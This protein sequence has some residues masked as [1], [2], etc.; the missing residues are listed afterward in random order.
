MKK[1]ISIIYSFRDRDLDRVKVSLDS[2]KRQTFN[3]FEVVFV[4]YGS[5]PGHSEEAKL[6]VESYPFAR[7]IVV[8]VYGKLWSRGR[9]MNIGVK[10]AIN[11]IIFVVDIDLFFNEIAL[12]E[13]IKNFEEG[14]Y[15]GGDWV[16]LSKIDSKEFLKKPLS[17]H[18]NVSKR[19]DD[20]GM[21]LT[22][23]KSLEKIHGYDEFFHIYGGEDTDLKFRLDL[24]GV[25]KRKFPSKDLFYHIWHPHAIQKRPKELVPTPWAYNIKRIN[26]KH[27]FY[28]QETLITVPLGQEKWGEC[29][30]AFID[31]LNIRRIFLPNIHSRILHFF[32]LILPLTSA[33]TLEIHIKEEPEFRSFK[34]KTKSIFNLNSEPYISMQEIN[35]FIT[36][37]LIFVYR[38]HQYAFFI[39]SESSEIMLKIEV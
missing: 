1:A 18:P 3:D 22:E 14:S 36:E 11:D 35:E 4:D 15:Y 10:M 28:N 21:I 25:S 9:A 34:A 23:K 24:V 30:Q 17:F 37:R 33:Q 38:N 19:S 12:E 26:E 16:F 20:N 2:L 5:D 13:A 8:P 32:N 39:N 31:S 6:L 29:D 7:F 27:V